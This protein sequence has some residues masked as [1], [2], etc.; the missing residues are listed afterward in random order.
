MKKKIRFFC[1]SVR[2]SAYWRVRRCKAG[3]KMTHE[4]SKNGMM[5]QV[6]GSLYYLD[7]TVIP[8]L[9]SLRSGDDPVFSFGV[10]FYAFK[11]NPRRVVQHVD[12]A[13][14][15]KSVFLD[16]M[17]HDLI[18]RMRIDAQV[19]DLCPAVIDDLGEK[20]VDCSV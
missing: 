1:I 17:L 18:V 13:A 16:Q 15:F 19:R 4:R 12:D 6:V 8:R 3:K 5:G 9:K 10:L 11:R 14:P 20:S 2:A 7:P